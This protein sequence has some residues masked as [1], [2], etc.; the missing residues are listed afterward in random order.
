MC[1][2]GTVVAPMK[3][4]TNW[5]QQK[6]ALVSIVDVPLL[7]N[8]P[9]TTLSYEKGGLVYCWRATDHDCF[10]RIFLSPGGLKQ[11]LSCKIEFQTDV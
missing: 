2:T 8:I 4:K 9:V 5:L 7:V 3:M 11:N 6:C 10:F 1:R